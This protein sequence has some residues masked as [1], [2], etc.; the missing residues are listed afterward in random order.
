MSDSYNMQTILLL[1]DNLDNQELILAFLE[2]SY[3]IE[4]VDHA[5]Q[6]LDL[7]ES[8]KHVID[9]ILCDI[10]LPDMDGLQFLKHIRQQIE[11]KSI[12]IIALTAHAMKGDK[13]RFLNAGFNDYLSKPIDGDILLELV[14]KYL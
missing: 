13:E 5:Q 14:E 2:D 6:A 3:Q 4:V 8:R 9:L 7:L 11:W 12:P 10:S 1:E